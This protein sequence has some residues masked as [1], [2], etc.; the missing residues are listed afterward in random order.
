MNVVWALGFILA[1]AISFCICAWDKKSAK[2]GGRRIPERVLW[3]LAVFFG[4]L[5]LYV[6]MR[7]FRHKTQKTGFVYGIPLLLVAQLFAMVYL[8]VFAV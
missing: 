6:C 8:G 2:S 5:G 3:L 7:I 1:N 4:A